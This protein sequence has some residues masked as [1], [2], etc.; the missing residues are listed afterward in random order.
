MELVAAGRI[1]IPLCRELYLYVFGQVFVTV[2][3]RDGL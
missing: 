2:H 3:S 1:I